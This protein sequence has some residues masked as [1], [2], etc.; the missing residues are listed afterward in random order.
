MENYEVQGLTMVQ[1]SV[2]VRGGQSAESEGQRNSCVNRYSPSSFLIASTKYSLILTWTRTRVPIE[3][4][5]PLQIV[6]HNNFAIALRTVRPCIGPSDTLANLSTFRE[7]D[8]VS[9]RGER[10]SLINIS[11]FF[12]SLY[13]PLYPRWPW[14]SRDAVVGNVAHLA[15]SEWPCRGLCLYLCTYWCV[16]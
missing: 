9:Y 7:F 10:E 5:R 16:A 2:I 11:S 4:L 6:K 1:E 14:H 3:R 15:S 13:K 8:D 12:L